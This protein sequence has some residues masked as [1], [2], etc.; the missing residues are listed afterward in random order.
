MALMAALDCWTVQR[1]REREQEL[2]FAGDAYRQAIRSYYFAAPAGAVRTLPTSLQAL[3][4]DERHPKA[5]HHL[6][7][8]YPDPMQGNAD[9]GLLR[10]GP[11]IYGVYSQSQAQPIK[12]DGFAPANAGFAGKASY[13]EWV[14]VFSAVPMPA[15]PA[16]PTASPPAAPLRPPALGSPP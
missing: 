14:F 10:A 6:R 7:R 4:E 5:L 1:Q 16:T 13:R 15:M 12:Q 3:L 9:W 2:L 8:L 11:L